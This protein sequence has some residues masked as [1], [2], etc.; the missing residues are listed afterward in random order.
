MALRPGRI[1]QNSTLQLTATFADSDGAALDP[2]VVTFRY[3]SPSG[4][5]DTTYTYGDDDELTRVSTGNYM[6]TFSVGE[7]AGRW[8]YRWSATDDETVDIIVGQE[9]DFLVQTSVF[10]DDATDY[11]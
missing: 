3:R 9:G 10:Y 1:Y 4:A 11:A 7:E 8:H 5:T 6:A 2:D